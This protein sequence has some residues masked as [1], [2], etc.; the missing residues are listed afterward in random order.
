MVVESFLKRFEGRD[1]SKEFV[2][3][4]SDLEGKVEEVRLWWCRIFVHDC[5]LV[6]ALVYAMVL[7]PRCLALTF[8]MVSEEE[9]CK[10]EYWHPGVT[11]LWR[12]ARR[13]QWTG[14]GEKD[15]SEEVCKEAGYINAGKSTATVGCCIRLLP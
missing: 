9:A 7:F 6:G 15:E 14:E 8:G 3:L 13:K 5:L 1:G 10:S 11:R 2:D 12:L 4:Q